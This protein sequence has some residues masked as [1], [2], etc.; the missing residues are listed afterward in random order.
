V[1]A[2]CL[3][4]GGLDSSTALAWAREQGYDCS[5]LAFDY[6]QRHRR[7]LQ[8]AEAISQRLGAEQHRVISF[9]L[10]SFGG[11]SLT[12]EMAVPL[13]GVQ[14]GVIPSTYV[15]ARN[16]IF[17]AFALAYAEV[18][19]AEAIVLGINALDYSGYPDCRPEYLEA[20]SGVAQLATRQG[21]EGRPP[22]LLAP[23]IELSK[24]EIVRLGSRL[25]V[26][27]ELTWSCYLGRSRACG[28][29]DSCRLRLKGFE[30]AGIRDPLEYETALPHPS[31]P[32]SSSERGSS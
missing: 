18:R 10:R 21:V 7:E 22:K 1:H 24:A 4:S 11:S 6:G 13:D 8:S 5:T 14:A 2:I 17:L 9:D 31:S 29:C 28:V 20:M 27:W 3:L 15:P 26:P 19:E 23:L 16:T 30:E 25:G 12:S 32:S